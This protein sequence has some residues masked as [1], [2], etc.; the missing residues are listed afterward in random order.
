[1]TSQRKKKCEQILGLC[2]TCDNLWFGAWS[3]HIFQSDK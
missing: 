2:M 1:M 3:W